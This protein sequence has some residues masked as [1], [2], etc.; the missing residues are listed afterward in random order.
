VPQIVAGHD[1]DRFATIVDVGGG[2]GTLLVAILAA[3]PHVHGSLV[4]LDPTATEAN[5]TFAAHHVENP[6]TTTPQ[7]VFDPLPRGADTHLLADI[8]HDRD[9]H[10][11]HRIPARCVETMDANSRIVVVEPV[12]GRLANTEMDLAMFVIFAG[13][14]RTVDEFCAFASGHGLVLD[15]V[16]DVSDQRCRLESAG[17]KSRT[18]PRPTRTPSSRGLR[19][20]SASGRW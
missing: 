1:W 12:G 13:R 9:D 5:R 8:L 2:H 14:E 15:T 4:D 7:S 3:H 18:S 17:P 10:N 19:P 11:A 6:A 16:K 20:I